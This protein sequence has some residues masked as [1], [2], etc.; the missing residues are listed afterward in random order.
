M[1]SNRGVIAKNQISFRSISRMSGSITKNLAPSSML[2][3]WT[4]T[5]IDAVRATGLQLYMK[6]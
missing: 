5:L 4:A 2:G 3:A 6:S 1:P